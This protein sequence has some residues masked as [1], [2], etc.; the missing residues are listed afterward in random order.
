MSDASDARIS[1]ERSSR[2]GR[3][4]AR[5]SVTAQKLDI[6]AKDLAGELSKDLP[7]DRSVPG[8]VD[9]NPSA[10]RAVE[11]GDP[12]RSLLYHALASPDVHPTLNSGSAIDEKNYPTWEQ[13]DV[14]ENYIYSLAPLSDQDLKDAVVGVF[15]YEY[16]P[17]EAT[18]HRQYADMVY[19]RMGIARTGT[20]EA[21]YKGV[22]RAYT[23]VTGTAGKIGV[24]PAAYGAFLARKFQ[25]GNK[26]S[27]LGEGIPDDNHRTFL[28]PFRKLFSGPEC[29][30]KHDI[31]VSFREQH[32][33]EK[34]ARIVQRVRQEDPTCVPKELDTTK[35]PFIRQS[36]DPDLVQMTPVGASVMI[37]L[38]RTHSFA[39]PNRM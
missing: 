1:S 16:R 30:P 39:R 5:F 25:G 36:P 28:L 10:K 32:R 7:I 13:L 26:L 24:Q 37:S 9:L 14:L 38:H 8:F 34:L 4:L 35:P 33:A 15:A 22:E 17:K 27:L 18:T 23:P 12:A 6:R 3:R 29:I 19:S 20:S 21:V 2:I 31:S 11:P